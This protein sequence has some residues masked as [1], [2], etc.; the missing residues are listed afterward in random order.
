[1]ATP[2]PSVH[3][4][5]V[6]RPSARADDTLRSLCAVA[7]EHGDRITVLAVAAEERESSG[8]CDTR[9]VLWNQVCRDFAREYLARAAQVVGTHHGNV[10]FGVLGT[11]AGRAVDGLVREASARGADEIVLADPRASGLGWFER[12][13]LRLVPYVAAGTTHSSGRSG[14]FNPRRSEMNATAPTSS[15]SQKRIVR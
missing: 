15:G 5:V 11:R 3:T 7:R 9:S 1:M 2:V 12:R 6:Y 13:R 10:E 8:C 14:L 4:L